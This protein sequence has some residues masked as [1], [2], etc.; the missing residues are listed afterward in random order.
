M[1]SLNV[2]LACLT[3][4]TSPCGE[5]LCTLAAAIAGGSAAAQ[6]KPGRTPASTRRRTRRLSDVV[7]VSLVTSSV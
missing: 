5:K 3:I 7:I 2:A 1:A 4:A 6:S